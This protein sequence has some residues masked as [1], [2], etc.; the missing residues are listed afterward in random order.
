MKCKF[1]SM[2]RTPSILVYRPAHSKDHVTLRHKSI[3]IVARGKLHEVFLGRKFT[4]CVWAPAAMVRECKL[5]RRGEEPVTVP[6][7]SGGDRTFFNNDQLLCFARTANGAWLPWDWQRTLSSE[8]FEQKYRSTVWFKE[9]QLGNGI[10]P[11]PGQ[12]PSV[13]TLGGVAE[14]LYNTD[15]LVPSTAEHFFCNGERIRGSDAFVLEYVARRHKFASNVWSGLRAVGFRPDVVPK[16]SMFDRR[17][18]VVGEYNHSQL[19]WPI[20][21]PV[22]P[23]CWANGAAM[24]PHDQVLLEEARVKLGLD[25]RRWVVARPN[26][27]TNNGVPGA[28]TTKVEVAV[29]RVTM[30]LLNTSQ[31]IDVTAGGTD[32]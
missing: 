3:N 16:A 32:W 18:G 4:S 22:P 19:V 28:V 20:P 14:R 29:P 24:L 7:S 11:R 26:M 6:Q 31:L 10:V 5:A 21:V 30:E 2:R 8:G 15:Q 27:V 23:H 25:S 17:C 12:T 1:S 9:Q 13:L